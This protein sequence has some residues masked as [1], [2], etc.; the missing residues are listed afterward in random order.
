M[1]STRLALVDGKGL[2]R[3]YFDGTKDESVNELGDAVR[4]LI[5]ASKP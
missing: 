1:H 5:A 4:K 3:G 2:V